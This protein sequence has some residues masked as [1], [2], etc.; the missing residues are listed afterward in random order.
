MRKEK[1]LIFN[2]STDSKNTSLGFAISWINKF[3]EHYLEVD[4]VTLHKGDLTG[5][6]KNIKIYGGDFSSSTRLIKFIKIRKIIKKL[7][8]KNDYKFCLAHMSASL[9]LVSSTIIRFKSIKTLF[10]YTHKG[11]KTIFKKIVL[12]I[13]NT[14]SDKIITASENSYPIKSKKVTSIGHAINYEVFYRNKKN[15]EQNNFLIISRISKSKNIELSIQGFLNSSYG[16]SNEITIIGGPL[17]NEDEIYQ[18]SLLKKYMAYPNVKFLGPVP[19]AELN[20]H[21][22]KAGFHINNTPEGFYDK[23]VLETMAGGLINFYNNSDYDRNINKNFLNYFKFDGSVE[24]LKNKINIVSQLDTE[25]LIKII[26]NIQQKASEES[27][28]TLHQRIINVI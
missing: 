8:K 28:E 9:L 20:K 1:L 5:L 23:S 19:H 7:I 3:S 21:I 6:N 14:I 10:W 2:I 18:N 25:E 12:Y 16:K 11:P 15:I 17:T 4:V 22:D 27:S 13:A 24:D 26:N